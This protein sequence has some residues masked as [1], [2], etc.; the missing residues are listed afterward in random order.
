MPLRRWRHAEWMDTM[1]V[2]AWWKRQKSRIVD[3][4]FIL[5]WFVFLVSVN[6]T[7]VSGTGNVRCW[8]SQHHQLRN[9]EWHVEWMD[10]TSGQ[11]IVG[12]KEAQQLLTSLGQFC[13]V[14]ICGARI[15]S[16]ADFC[17]LIVREA[18]SAEEWRVVCRMDEYNIQRQKE[19]W[20]EVSDSGRREVWWEI[21]SP[22]NRC[23]RCDLYP[24]RRGLTCRMN[25]Y[26]LSTWK[27]MS[28]KVCNPLNRRSISA[29]FPS[30]FV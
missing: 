11:D 9:E 27:R 30:L 22:P 14:F 18:P 6:S 5:Y 15:L 19:V 17:T 25:G 7:I 23:A 4:F 28:R 1:S 12:S 24:S 26:F 10:T 16:G 13:A 20:W 2:G 3:F 8:I 29:L 21:S